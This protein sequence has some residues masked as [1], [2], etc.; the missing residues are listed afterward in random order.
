MNKEESINSIIIKKNGDI[1]EK[2]IKI[3]EMYKSCNFKISKH[4][5][6]QHEYKC[7]NNIYEVYGKK[8]GKANT[9]NKYDYPPPIDNTLFFGNMCILMKSNNKYEEL[10][11]IEWNKVYEK[12]FGGFYDL[13]SD[14]ET[15]SMD[16][17]IYNSD[18]YTKE[19]YHKDGF[20][21][22]DKE[23]VEEDYI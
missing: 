3:N 11:K 20:I 18:E 14:D 19:G 9:E 15:R 10:T 8:N 5:E 2:N 4:F 21:V 23:L 22:D 17:E 1:Q 6:K 16:S 13:G 7:N 12:L